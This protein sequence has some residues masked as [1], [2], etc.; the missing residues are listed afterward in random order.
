[1][2][3][4]ISKGYAFVTFEKASQALAACDGSPYPLSDRLLYATIASVRPNNGSTDKNDHP[5]WDAPS[6]ALDVNSYRMGEMQ[7]PLEP[8]DP[9]YETKN[10]KII[11]NNAI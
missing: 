6:S 9:K 11:D 4:G 10:I 1:M 3:K 2:S 5:Q 8:K 7:V